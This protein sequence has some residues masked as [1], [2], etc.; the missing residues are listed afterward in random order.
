[1]TTPFWC[2]FGAYHI[3][4]IARNVRGREAQSG[5]K[6]RRGPGFWLQA[7]LM[8]TAV[9]IANDSGVL[10]RDLVNPLFVAL[11]MAIGY[12]VHGASL[13]VT[14]LSRD[15]RGLAAGLGEYFGEW[16]RRG[17]YFTDTPEVF[18]LLVMNSIVEETIYRGAAQPLLAQATDSPWLAVG[19]VAV[20]FSAGHR[21]FLRGRLIE[22][23]EFLLY[24]LLL[25]SL[26]HWTGSL[27]LVIVVHTVRNFELHFQK[28]LIKVEELGNEEE[29]IAAAEKELRRAAP[30]NS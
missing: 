15:Y 23:V 24:A 1:M 12:A 27:I 10:S 3:I 4:A 18:F 8:A 26:Y 29:A 21:H 17:R 13:L 19:V 11:G 9:W 2:L 14:N 7:P 16:A 28:F 30:E 22:S 25:G 5:E 6:R 20:L